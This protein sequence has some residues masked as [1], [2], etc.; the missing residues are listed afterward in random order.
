MSKI[1]LITLLLS[2]CYNTDSQK[3]EAT[4]S[5]SH[6]QGAIITKE[7]T[8]IFY[9]EMWNDFTGMMYNL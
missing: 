8:M 2:G 9:H 7:G 5:T 1:I 6:P 3:P 4:Y